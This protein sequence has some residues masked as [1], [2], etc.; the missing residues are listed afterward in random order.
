MHNKPSILPGVYVDWVESIYGWGIFTKDEIPMHT[1]IETC[2]VIVYPEDIIKIATWNTQDD[3]HSYASLGLTLYSLK[4]GEQHAAI[5]LGFGGIY[6]HSDNNN[7][8]FVMNAEEGFLHIVT[9]RD[10][11]PGEQ[12]LV[13]YGDDWFEGKPFPKVDL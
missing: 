3:R 9:L 8:Q 6:N 1:V 11:A 10:I 12:L 2:P 7:C 5:P 4:W 13:T